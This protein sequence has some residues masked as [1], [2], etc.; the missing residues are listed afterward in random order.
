[1]I[2]LIRFTGLNDRTIGRLYL[3]GTPLYYSI[4]KPWLNNEPFVSCIP[5]GRYPLTRFDS[6][7]YGPDTWMVDEV[8]DRSYILFHVANVADNV[9][10]CIGLGM[11]VYENLEGVKSSRIAIDDFYKKTEFFQSEEIEIL[12]GI[13]K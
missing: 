10:G 4:E 3:D 6:P 5:T 7:S 13:I 8:P 9:Q 11:G 1:M 12:N 2:K